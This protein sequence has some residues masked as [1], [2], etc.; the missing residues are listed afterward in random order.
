MKYFR[1][2]LSQRAIA[3]EMKVSRTTVRKYIRDYEAKLEEIDELTKGGGGHNSLALNLAAEMVSEPKYDTSSRTRVK[4]TDEVIE[5]IE[6]LLQENDRNRLL[7][8]S[9][10]LMKKID[11]HEMLIKQGFD[12]SYPTVCNY[13]RD[14]YDKKEAFIR[15]E[16]DLGET[17]EFDWGEVKLTI[18]GKPMT[19]Q[20][21]LLTTACGSHHYSRLYQKV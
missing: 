14:N 20:M 10:Q 8:R 17:L 9:K 19:L 7:G 15:Q 21:G 5:M 12:I 3:K 16:Y 1:D 11:I 6:E 2:N 18:G 4:L 13:I